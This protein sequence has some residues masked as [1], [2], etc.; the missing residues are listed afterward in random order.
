VRHRL[1]AVDQLDD[2]A[3]EVGGENRLEPKPF[4]QRDKDGDQEERRA[5]AYLRR[6]VLQSPERRGDAHRVLSL[7]HCKADRDN[8]QAEQPE[9][10]EL[11]ADPAGSPEKKSDSK[12]IVAISAIEAPAMTS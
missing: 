5:D 3:D 12:T 9:Q 10:Q 6:R 1:V 8:E 11:Y 2:G 7:Q 4:G